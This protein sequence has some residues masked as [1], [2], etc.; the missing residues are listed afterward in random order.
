MKLKHY[1][2]CNNGKVE[3]RE[4]IY[5]K[6]KNKLTFKSVTALSGWVYKLNVKSVK[7]FYGQKLIELEGVIN[8]LPI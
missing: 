6:Y 2:E 5:I 7:D 8:E 3:G 1:L 4:I